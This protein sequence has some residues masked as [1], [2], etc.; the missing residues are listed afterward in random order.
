LDEES[1]RRF[2]T[3]SVP[4]LALGSFDGS[5]S[6]QR[7]DDLA[8]PLALILSDPLQCYRIVSLESELHDQMVLTRRLHHLHVS[9]VQAAELLIEIAGQR[10]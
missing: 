6:D 10:V 2:E 1:I 7:P 4:Q 9:G 3:R 8:R 5:C